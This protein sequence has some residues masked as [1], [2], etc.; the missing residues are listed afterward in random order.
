[1]CVFV[2]VCVGGGLGVVA[3]AEE[4]AVP[5]H[6]NTVKIFLRPYTDRSVHRAVLVQ[7]CV[8]GQR[9]GEKERA[10]VL[11]EQINNHAAEYDY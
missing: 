6:L 1:M 10:G 3:G 11:L 8:D 7:V 9:M 5:P 2:Y 4:D